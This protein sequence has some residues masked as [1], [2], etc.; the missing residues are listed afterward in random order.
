MAKL[1]IKFVQNYFEVLVF[2]HLQSFMEDIVKDSIANLDEDVIKWYLH[3]EKKPINEVVEFLSILPSFIEEDH[4]DPVIE[5]FNIAMKQN[6]IDDVAE[7]LSM[8][9]P[10]KIPFFLQSLDIKIDAQKFPEIYEYLV[11]LS[12]KNVENVD[13]IVRLTQN[14][15]ILIN[16]EEIIRVINKYNL[17]PIIVDENISQ[18][19]HIAW[20]SLDIA[21]LT[22]LKNFESLYLSSMVDYL[23]SIF[24]DSDLS[25][26]IDFISQGPLP[27]DIFEHELENSRVD[28]YSVAI[29]NPLES[30]VYL[31]GFESGKLNDF[32]PIIG[33][34]LSQIDE[35]HHVTLI[36][37]ECISDYLLV[38]ETP[39]EEVL[40]ILMNLDKK[41]IACYEKYSLKE[42]VSEDGPLKYFNQLSE[43][44]DFYAARVIKRLIENASEVESLST[45]ESL[46]IN[47]NK[48][49]KF[50]IKFIATISGFGKFLGSKNLDRIKNYVFSEILSVKKDDEILTEGLKWISLCLPFFNTDFDADVFPVHKL[51]LVL[52]LI[53]EWLNSSVA[54]DD[55]F[56]DMRVQLTR[57]MGYIHQKQLT[58]PDNFQDLALKLL[59]NNMEISQLE[60]QRLDLLY[61]TLKF[62]LKIGNGHFEQELLELLLTY[63]CNKQNQACSLVESELQRTLQ[64]TNIGIKTLQ[65]KKDSIFRLF[66]ESKS[67]S[68]QRICAWFLQK[69]I[70]TEQPEFVVEYQLSKDD[71]L[72]AKIPQ[73]L[74]GIISKDDGNHAKYFWSWYLIFEFFEDVT[75]RIKTDYVNQ[76][77]ENKELFILFDYIFEVL[78]FDDKFISGLIV[79]SDNVI[80]NYDL[81]ETGKREILEDELKYLVVNIYYKC[82]QHCGSQVQLWFKEIRDR[83]FKNKVEKFTVKYVSSL[84]IS[85]ILNQVSD[86]KT[87]IE[88][89]EENM[90]IKVNQVTN[91]IRT[92]YVIDDQKMEMMIKIPHNYPLDNVSVEGPLRLGVKENQWKAWLLASQ[93]VISLTNGSI[94]ESIELFCKNVNLH[95]SGF[96]DCAICY[97]ILHQD[98]S[99]PSKTCPTCSNKFHAACLYKWFK[100]SGSST[101]PLCRSAFNFRK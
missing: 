44:N 65:S 21:L 10:G 53:D 67:T 38:K 68:T 81:I 49:M 82:L 98:L 57:F 35:E 19:L 69:I 31:T 63:N 9:K 22:Q 45:F 1:D 20:S 24:I 51:T 75:L 56:I 95:F 50:P 7:T 33:K 93:R 6:L 11:G 8:V 37:R 94:I 88:G 5:L 89:K 79:D 47:Y 41:I 80:P 77:L 39:A 66:A 12:K 18:I 78:D 32:V 97:S 25:K 58:I 54:Y 28:I 90:N 15:D 92:T 48:L 16:D 26:L 83:Q 4:I 3:Y 30:A 23:K 14:K 71:S 55:K 84:L 59:E 34:V 72:Q 2:L 40:N 36:A 76:L 13:M 60:P 91:E 70:S 100:S 27:M 96:E 101:C 74:M 17:L 73:I 99:L 46:E 85:K 29:S 52:N 86:Q 42:L 61:Y 87:K 62:Y 43:D 64:Q